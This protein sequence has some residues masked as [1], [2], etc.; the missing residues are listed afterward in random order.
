MSRL[1][2]ESSIG[3][4]LDREGPNALF[5]KATGRLGVIGKFAKEAQ[6]AGVGKEQ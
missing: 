1:V 3:I 4:E 2:M 5:V 6:R